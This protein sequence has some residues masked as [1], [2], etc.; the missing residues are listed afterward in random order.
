MSAT[1]L[2]SASFSYDWHYNNDGTLNVESLFLDARGAIS[3][4]WTLIS[5]IF[6]FF[7]QSGFSALEVGSVRP[8]NQK[9]IIVKNCADLV[10]GSFSWLLFGYGAAYGDSVGSFIG[11]NLFFTSGVNDDGLYFIFQLAFA[12]TCATIDSGVVA[13][14]I[15]LTAYFVSSFCI[16]FFVYPI[17]CHWVWNGGGF[18]SSMGYI[19]FAGTTVVHMVGGVC[20]FVGGVFLGP[21]IGRFNEVT[22]LPVEMEKGLPSQAAIGA[23]IL[24]ICWF[25]FN[26]GSSAILD[27]GWQTAIKCAVNTL[28][29]AVASVFMSVIFTKLVFGR[30]DMF[31]MLNSLLAGLVSVTGSCASIST[32][33]A[34]ITGLVAGLIF[35]ISTT[36]LLYRFNIDDPL[37]AITVH[38]FSGVWGAISTGLFDESNGLFYGGGFEQLGIQIFGVFVLI[39]WSGTLMTIVYWATEKF[40]CTIRVPADVERLGCDAELVG[41]YAD[42][43][44]ILEDLLLDHNIH[45]LRSFLED[46]SAVE[47]LDLFS[48]VKEFEA[49]KVK[50]SRVAGKIFRTYIEPGCDK[51][52]NLPQWTVNNVLIQINSFVPDSLFDEVKKENMK[53]MQGLIDL[54]FEDSPQMT[55]FLAAKEAG[56]DRKCYRVAEALRYMPSRGNE[57]ASID[58]E[59]ER[60]R[61]MAQWSFPILFLGAGESGKSTF[62]FQARSI[63][64]TELNLA[65]VKLCVKF[66]RLNSLQTL[67]H[68]IS[69]SQ[70]D[71]FEAT[72][73]K[74]VERAD[75][76]DIDEIMNYTDEVKYTTTVAQQLTR[77]WKSPAIQKTFSLRRH[78][79]LPE[80][81]DYYQENSLRFCDTREYMFS[82][83]P[84]DLLR[85]RI[86]TTGIQE[87]E[88]PDDDLNK[89]LNVLAWNKAAVPKDYSLAPRWKII[90]FGGQR[91]ERRKWLPH[92]S[93]AAGVLFFVNLHGYK[94]VLYEDTKMLRVHEDLDLVKK[95]LATNFKGIP[96]GIVFTKCDLFKEDYDEKE[97]QRAFP[98]FEGKSG[99]DAALEHFVGAFE[100]N[101]PKDRK[102]PVCYSIISTYEKKQ[103]GGVLDSIQSRILKANRARLADIVG[104]SDDGDDGKKKSLVGADVFVNVDVGADLAALKKAES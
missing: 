45:F 13:E 74:G 76:Q 10:F 9:S 54:Y 72:Y 27:G 64:S 3:T 19:D 59:L 34:I 2:D 29:G 44:E 104:I 20:G 85:V 84:K 48:A 77:V 16:C 67:Q 12:A 63:Y 62:F 38:G 95:T 69:V 4:E 56:V 96:V 35:P 36:L 41:G 30:Y 78:Y 49:A 11:K 97:F 82:P 92:M 70:D 6:I 73:L 60:Q 89:T 80:N 8:T 58:E 7:M 103:V 71:E 68:L 75:A 79:W 46:K 39:V 101:I 65:Y 57:S 31:A 90:D 98:D 28:F 53:M 93:I 52:V 94:V 18:L 55:L 14:R 81:T 87:F 15:S 99:M 26:A 66:L 32:V 1:F 23:W 51:Q 24:L 91:S 22:G 102:Y 25:F 47:L 42:N 61:L 17:P 86:K 100:K 50:D 88:M 21:R 5:A 40:V 37:D 43:T 33:D 83:S